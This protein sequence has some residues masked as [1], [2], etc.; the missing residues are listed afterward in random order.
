MERSQ[1]SSTRNPQDPAHAINCVAE[2]MVSI[3]RQIKTRESSAL[4][5]QYPK[6]QDEIFEEMVVKMIVKIPESEEKYLWKRLI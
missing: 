2:S 6:S 5:L 4:T 3:A 1:R